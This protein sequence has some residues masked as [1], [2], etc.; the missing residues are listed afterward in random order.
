MSPGRHLPR[1]SAV[2]CTLGLLV[3]LHAGVVAGGCLLEREGGLDAPADGGVC[4]DGVVAPGEEC[5][6]GGETASCD[7]D[8][9]LVA[10][11]DGTVNA[12]AGEACDDANDDDTD[13]CRADCSLT[14]CGNGVLDDAE[15]CDDGNDD[16]TDACTRGCLLARCG[17]GFV[18]PGAGEACDDGDGHNDDACPDGPGGTCQ[19]AA[20]GDGFLQEGVEECDDGNDDDSDECVAGCLG[21]RCGDG[22]LRLTGGSPEMCDDG[23]A[24][25]GDGCGAGC[26]RETGACCEGQPGETSSCTLG[27]HIVPSAASL[28]LDI[29]DNGYPGM[30][31]CVD[32]TFPL[33][34]CGAVAEVEIEMAADHTWVSDVVAYTVHDGTRVDLVDRPKL[35]G[36]GD[37]SNLSASFPITF[38]DDASTSAEDLGGDV[39]GG[40]ICEG[41]SACRYHPDPGSLADFDGA[42]PAGTWTFCAGDGA[43]ND[44]GTLE[45]VV[46]TIQTD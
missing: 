13:G 7:A 3:A 24:M 20:C 16:D 1:L 6:D 15:E 39:V 35:P 19:P 12:F 26:A 2:R 4:G 38:D 9:T 27:P 10:C 18:Q 45:Q 46:F 29:P 44:E 22:F 33:T 17:D 28:G 14:S 34:G 40:T 32:V 8:C 25:A 21:A 36:L 30:V 41:N 31:A 5:D 42:S 43:N 23:N 11:G 37:S